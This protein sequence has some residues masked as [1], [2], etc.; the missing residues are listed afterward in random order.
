[1]SNRVNSVVRRSVPCYFCNE[2]LEEKYL[3]D[4]VKHCGLVLEECPRKCGVYVPRKNMDEHRRLCCTD[5]A[6]GNSQAKEIQDFA[7]RNKIF[8]ALMLLRAVV[9][10]E[11]KERKHVQDNVSQCFKLLRAQQASIDTLRLQ[12]TRMAEESQQ[13][14]VTLNQRLNELALTRDNTEQRTSLSFQHISEQ[15]KLLHGELTDEQNKHEDVFGN[16]YL[17]LKD[18]KAF[19][20]G[21][22]AHMSKMWQEQ[23]ELIHD[24]KLEL[25]MRCKNSKELAA[26]QKLLT[27]KIDALEEEVQKQS[28]LISNQK[29]I[30]KGLKFQM[31]E[32]LKY[33]EELID[34]NS[35]LKV[36]EHIECRCEHEYFD[37]YSSNGRLLWR[38]DRYKEKMTDAKEND[39]ALYSPKFLNKEYGYTLRLELF[40]NGIGQ[41]KDRHIIGCLRVETGKWDPLL[42]WPC[43]LKAT[44][45]LRNQENPANDVKKIVKAVGQDKT[46]S[47]DIT[48]ESGIYMFIPHTTL[49]RYSGYV[50]D[51]VLFLD[52]QVKDIKT[53]VSTPSLIS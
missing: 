43:I 6:A 21:E 12:I 19:L 24:L 9:N 49:T 41:W 50:K 4:H 33:L 38:I 13:Y 32:N 30:V 7:W 23:Q 31:K 22:S 16:W 53:S 52:I 10:N 28:T 5:A 44:V 26:Q 27:E 25:E 2:F 15:L 1:M 14:N 45:T 20:A 17:E 35:R 3:F 46:N 39:C 8:S 36:T 29:S 48:K 47:T 37:Q 40:L 11:E 42:D 51:D 18:L 34:E